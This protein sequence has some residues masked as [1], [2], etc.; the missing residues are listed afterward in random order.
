MITLGLVKNVLRLTLRGWNYCQ[1][2]IMN[3]TLAFLHWDIDSYN[4]YHNYSLLNSATFVL[5]FY[6]KNKFINFKKVTRSPGLLCDINVIMIQGCKK[7]LL[8]LRVG[9]YIS[10]LI[11]KKATYNPN[12]PLS[13]IL[14]GCLKII[15]Y[16]RHY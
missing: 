10:I 15:E 9:N 7:I 6:D 4:F 12:F 5:I 2:K 16:K 14:L 13:L 1:K 3:R 8:S 11:S